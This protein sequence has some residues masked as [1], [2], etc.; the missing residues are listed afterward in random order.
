MASW[1]ETHG[2]AV[3]LTMRV[4]D[5]ILRRRVSAVSKDEATELEI[6]SEPLFEQRRAR[7]EG[8]ERRPELRAIAVLLLQDLVPGA[9]DHKVRAG[10]QVIGELLDRRGRDDGVVAGGEHQD[11]LADFRWIIRRA[12]AV[13]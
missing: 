12:E 7:H 11:R 9:G 3:L 5:L 1:F 13:H 4:S 2:I 10:A 8:V 6:G